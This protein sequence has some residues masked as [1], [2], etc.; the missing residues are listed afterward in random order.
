MSASRR[1]RVGCLAFAVAAG[2]VAVNCAGDDAGSQLRSTAARAPANAETTV[3]I[4][5]AWTTAVPDGL[6]SG[7]KL[8]APDG[9]YPTGLPND[10]TF[11]PIGVWLETV[12]DSSQV[13]MDRSVGLNLYVA[14]A[15]DEVADL[16]AIESGGMHL[17]LQADEWAD[18]P[19]AD[20]PAVDG[21]LV[22]DEA[23]LMYRAGWDEWT[24]T[25]GWNTCTPTQD[26]GGQ[27]GYTVM[28]HYNN[29]VPPG[30]LR[31]ANYG[32]DVLHWETDDEADVFIN[33]GFQDVVSADDYAFT[34]PDASPS[35]RRGSFYGWIVQRIRDLDG[36]DGVR[37]PVWS[38]VE[39]GH[40]FEDDSAPTITAPQMRSAVWH[41]IIAGA[42]GVV[43]F[44]HSFGG[45]CE[46]FSVLRGGC[47]S[48]MVRTV[49]EVTSQ[50]TELAP[51]LNAPFAD[52]YV[53]AGGPAEVMAKLGPDG[54]WYVFAGADTVG[55]DGGDVAFGVAAGS[56]V[57]VLYEN[58]TLA[59]TDGR[60][61]DT[62]ADGNAVHIYRVT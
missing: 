23:D 55:E 40:P 17:L 53:R 57:E 21:W 41:S 46:T 36:R 13:A 6:P 49:K 20:N 38:F 16:D 33:H 14:L 3:T 47:D 56:N 2:C 15:H 1:A 43:F 44:N 61:V 50:I 18:D 62:F 12:I 4:P 30:A 58:R 29:Q 48:K 9:S 31:Y 25:P 51:V 24:G 54:A 27:C 26:D 8:R 5:P 45:P 52:G 35:D 7:V 10:P 34:H 39:L 28:E 19:R 60:F 11:F 37:Q 32:L 42:R 22:Y 59:V